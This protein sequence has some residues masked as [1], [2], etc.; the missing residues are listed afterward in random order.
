MVSA[1]VSVTGDETL[2]AEAAMVQGKVHGVSCDRSERSGPGEGANS[3]EA[4]DLPQSIVTNHEATEG[5]R[6]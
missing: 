2:S 3:L 6:Y 4:I 1:K 5:T